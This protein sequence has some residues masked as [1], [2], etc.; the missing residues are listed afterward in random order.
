[1]RIVLENPDGPGIFHAGERKAHA[2]FG[3]Q[4]QAREMQ[5]VVVDRLSAGNAR[6]MAGQPFFFASVREADGAIFSHMLAC[7]TTAAGTYPL[8]A[9]GD[10]QTFYFLLGEA[11]G[12]RFWQ[13]VA[14]GDG[15][16]GMIFVDFARRARLRVNGTLRQA[17][18]GALPGFECPPGHRLVQA[19]VEQAYTNCQ[20]RIVRLKAA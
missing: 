5:G 2:L 20:T 6:F 3:V 19:R 7:V 18:P 14:Q 9:F 8:V 10:A 4:A 15:K 12:G 11:S 13:A 17:A 16:A 1:M